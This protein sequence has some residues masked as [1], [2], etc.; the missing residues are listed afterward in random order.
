MG[1]ARAR[2]R[3]RHCRLERDDTMTQ[4]SML[5]VSGQTRGYRFEEASSAKGWHE[6]QA[7]SARPVTRAAPMCCADGKGTK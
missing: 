2:T 7:C 5:G 3:L 6:W 1:C 4:R